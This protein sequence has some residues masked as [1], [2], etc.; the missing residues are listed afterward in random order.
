MSCV[1]PPQLTDD[2]LLSYLDGEADPLVVQHLDQ[3]PFCRQRAAELRNYVNSLAARLFRATC[4]SSLE[5][6]EYHV[7]LLP[8][9]EASRVGAH[10]DE[11]PHCTAELAVIVDFMAQ[12]DPVPALDILG[13]VKERAQV[14]IAR[15]VSGGRALGALATPSP[16]FAP[17]LAGVRGTGAGPLIF[18]AE[19]IQIAVEF[20]VDAQPASQV[21]LLGLIQ[22]PDDFSGAP[23]RVWRDGEL[24]A[25]EA[26]DDVGNFVIAGLEPGQYDLTIGETPLQVQIPLLD[27]PAS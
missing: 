20:Q 27:V 9:P 18:E 8:A 12:P 4:P 17:V 24:I 6:G 7:G 25:T 15:L 3:C 21:S 22:G 14:L 13:P 2:A 1:L 10:V 26:V 19:E 11:C 16:A 5:L 23:V